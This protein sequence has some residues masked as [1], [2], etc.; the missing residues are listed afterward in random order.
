[1]YPTVSKIARF[2][3]SYRTASTTIDN[4]NELLVEGWVIISIAQIAESN[5]V[6][7]F[8]EF[9]LGLPIPQKDPHAKLL[10]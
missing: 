5:N 7:G 3:K 1:M 4:I 8:T 10:H 9:I 6:Y 2:V